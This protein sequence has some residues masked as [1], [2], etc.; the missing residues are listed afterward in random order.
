MCKAIVSFLKKHPYYNAVIH[1]IAGLGL[2]IILA[3][4]LF[5]IHPIRYGLLLLIIGLLAHLYPLTLSK[6]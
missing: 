4:P 3:R 6:N 5:T 1:T 2:G